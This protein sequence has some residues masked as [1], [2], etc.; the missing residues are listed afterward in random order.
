MH[1]SIIGH[2]PTREQSNTK[3]QRLSNIH[4]PH[5]CTNPISVE[6]R[7]IP[8]RTMGPIDI[9][10]A[11]ATNFTT[12]HSHIEHLTN[13][14]RNVALHA[15]INQNQCLQ[16]R[17]GCQTTGDA[18][19]QAGSRQIQQCQRCQWG[20]FWGNGNSL[21]RYY[22]WWR[23]FCQCLTIGHGWTIQKVARY[24]DGIGIWNGHRCDLT[25]T[26]GRCL[27][28]GSRYWNTFNNREP[29]DK[30]NV[31]RE[32]NDWR[33]NQAGAWL[34]PWDLTIIMNVRSMRSSCWILLACN[35]S[36]RWWHDDYKEVRTRVKKGIVLD[37]ID[38]VFSKM[39]N[40]VVRWWGVQMLWDFKDFSMD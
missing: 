22:L 30:S 16:V 20:H 24:L 32:E 28:G 7:F 34:V 40:A 1:P 29:N 31:G 26:Q 3:S 9:V 14:V 33:D 27:G 25:W 12:I 36:R 4:M 39:K 23:H 11:F 35:N 37:W 17:Q 10:D 21:V 38:T 2:H 5:S 18:S 13:R 15:V 6:R 19:N 8:L